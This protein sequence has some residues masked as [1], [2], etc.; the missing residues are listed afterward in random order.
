M[1][2]RPYQL[3]DADACLSLFESNVPEYFT[4]AERADFEQFL[5]RDAQ[6]CD[7][8]LIEHDDSVVACGGLAIRADG[9]AVFCWGMV[10]RSLQRRGLG[11]Q[12]SL[13]RLQQARQNPNVK[14]IELS[15]S[16]HTQDFYARLGFSVTRVVADGH[17]PGL[18]AVEMVLVLRND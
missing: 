6:G 17:G 3:A 4:L 11:R 9:V 10:E 12:L 18:D 1:P 15:T 8:Q 13:A 2:I 14:R 7:Y 5:R 16:Q